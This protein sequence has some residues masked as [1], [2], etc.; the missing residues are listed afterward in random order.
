MSTA[1]HLHTKAAN[2]I[3]DRHIHTCHRNRVF[4]DNQTSRKCSSSAFQTKPLRPLKQL[5]A[6]L[7]REET[8][9]NHP[10]QIKLEQ[11]KDK[12]CGM[13][14][15]GTA[16]YSQ[17]GH[18]TQQ[19]VF[20]CIFSFETEEN[21]SSEQ[22]VD[23]RSWFLSCW[24]SETAGHGTQTDNETKKNRDSQS[25]WV[26]AGTHFIKTGNKTP[27]TAFTELDKTETTK[28]DFQKHWD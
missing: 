25:S 14:N 8:Y 1:K 9:F 22:N 15:E 19:K 7:T 12:H 26:W 13:Q 2:T 5:Q 18:K 24:L 20:F 16:N 23:R 28:K 27:S 17:K 10:V 3:S 21:K 4:A 11:S 6:P